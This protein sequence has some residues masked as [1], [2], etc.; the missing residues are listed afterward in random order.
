MSTRR[1]RP[2]VAKGPRPQLLASPFEDKLLKM[3]MTLA[4][5]LA[6]LRERTEM[7][8]EACTKAGVDVEALT[9]D[10]APEREAARAQRHRELAEKLLQI[11]DE[12]G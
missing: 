11:L 6:V 3:I 2:R 5:E 12:D 10:L 8:A 9:E 7:L 1:A 4:T